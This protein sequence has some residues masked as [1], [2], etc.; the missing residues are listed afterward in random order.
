MVT[1][2]NHRIMKNVFRFV[3]IFLGAFFVLT[4]SLQALS[5]TTTQTT[6]S[7]SVTTATASPIL[8]SK[9]A[10]VDIDSLPLQDNPD[11]YQFD[12]P[13]S[14]V[15]MYITVRKGNISDNTD[16]SW[17]EVN[18]F[19]KWDNGR[20]ADVVVGRA[21]A[22]LQVG[23][24]SG[25]LPSELGYGLTL[26]N[27][28]IQI[29]G[30]STSDKSI[31][32]Y[33]IELYSQSESWRGQRTF[34]LNKHLFD[35]SRVRNKLNFD[36]MSRISNMFSLRTQFV[37]L[38]VKDETTIPPKTTFVDYGLFTQVEQPN[39][40]FLK[41]HGLD[42]NGQLYKATFFEFFRYP[43]QIRLVDDPLYDEKV[44]SKI[45]EIKGN[46]DHTKLIQMLDDINNTNI[47]IEQTFEKHFNVDN[48]FTWM[49]YNILVGNV[50]T[51]S[52][53][54]FL[55]SPGN[56]NMWYFLPWDYDGSLY[57]Q[58][59]LYTYDPFEY[60]VANYWGAVLHNRVLKVARYRQIL[61]EKVNFLMAY[62]TPE[63]IQ[64]MLNRYRDVTDVYSLAPPDSVYLS[65]F[66]VS[67]ETSLEQIPTEIQVN[68]DLYLESLQSPMPFFL[69]TPKANGDSLVFN[70][71]ESYD[72]NAQN[73]TYDFVVSRNWQ[74]SD[75]VYEKTIS[76]L[77]LIEIEKL[78]PGTYFWRVI[79]TN[80]SGKSQLPFDSYR[81][82]G[83][84]QQYFGMK[85]LQ[86]TSNGQVLE[87]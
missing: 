73:I 32:S 60:G 59:N 39:T 48:Y 64:R 22:I 50:D 1:Y 9:E 7:A 77:T 63:R 45:L 8:V 4:V 33:K 29:R 79:A 31:K 57:R 12:D 75:I 17:D 38:F 42:P 30:N 24:E 72:F 35:S 58:A 84:S 46:N 26:P 18:S 74:F 16:Y 13:D 15:V 5:A 6:P 67:Y 87:K 51:Q 36:L 68:Y 66:P 62:L 19:S 20:P 11:I 28:T 78:E 85:Y 83:S 54:Y 55:Y 65:T 14:V 27:A 43:D 41:N 21:E 2:W 47:P 53:N 81:E 44:F 40:R 86:I 52:Q 3:L 37:R 70:W 61:D 76:G 49:A 56:G 10:Q 71:G 82:S 23:D 69:G 80:E 25:P 34:N